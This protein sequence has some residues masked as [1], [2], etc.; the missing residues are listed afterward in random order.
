MVMWNRE[1]DV[2][3]FCDF[4]KQNIMVMC[5]FNIYL[6][7]YLDKVIEMLILFLVIQFLVEYFFFDDLF[8]EFLLLK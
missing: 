6:F 4:G 2:M 8:S 1:L 3:I 7:V 5:I